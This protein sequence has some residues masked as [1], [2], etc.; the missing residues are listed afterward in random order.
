MT[1]RPHIQSALVAALASFVPSIAFA[2]GDAE[3]GES[4]YNRQCTICHD[5][6][7]G[8]QKVGPSMHAIFGRQAGTVQGF[9]LYRG[10]RDATWTWDDKT[11]DAYLADPVAYTKENNGGK[12][13]S[14][15]LKLSSPQDRADVIAYL[16]T[17]K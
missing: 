5:T 14:M 9:Q 1:I 12:G 15:I 8:K 13:T 3:R 10:L 2:S 4:V 17:L 16:K 6:A 7:A 11:L